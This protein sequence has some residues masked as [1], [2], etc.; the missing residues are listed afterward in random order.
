[1]TT[2]AETGVV[3]PVKAAGAAH[4][5]HLHTRTHGLEVDHLRAHATWPHT[6]HTV[7]SQ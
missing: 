7:V 1:M 6:E 2:G 5:E 4:K 3:V